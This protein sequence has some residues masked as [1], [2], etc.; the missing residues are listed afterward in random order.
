MIV[1]K[2]K[3]SEVYVFGRYAVKVFKRD[4][5]YNFKKEVKFLTILQPFKFV[6]TLY[7]IDESN[8]RIVMEFINGI[9]IGDFIRYEGE[10]RIRE[11]LAKCYDICYLL[12]LLGIQKEELS[13][14]E[15]HIIIRGNNVF[16]VDFE[17]GLLR[18]KPA[19]VT[20][21]SAYVI[22]RVSNFVD[23]DVEKLKIFTRDYK[24]SRRFEDFVKI[25]KLILRR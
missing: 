11:I 18:D 19:N 12:D 20:Q 13:K 1:F 16:F 22:S 10:N 14:P 8:L 5:I 21:F 7:F 17:R 3:H 24:R 2:G 6:P 25:K 23:L 15:K 4:F 9:R